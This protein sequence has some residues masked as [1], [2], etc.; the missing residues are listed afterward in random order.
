MNL[1][2]VYAKGITKIRKEIWANPDAHI[3]LYKDE[4]GY[5]PWGTLHDSWGERAFTPEEFQRSRK[6][7]MI[8]LTDEDWIEYSP[9]T[10]VPEVSDSSEVKE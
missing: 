4:K 7:L 10:I 5:G 9:K 2:E 8:G 6:I 3:E 1:K